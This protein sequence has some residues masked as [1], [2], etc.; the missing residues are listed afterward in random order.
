MSGAHPGSELKVNFHHMAIDTL[1]LVFHTERHGRLICTR[2]EVEA[3]A[4]RVRV[5]QMVTP[6]TSWQRRIHTQ[7]IAFRHLPPNSARF[8]YA[9]EGA[10]FICAQL[11]SDAVSALRKGW[12]LI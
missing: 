1:P 7:S 2:E 3:D 9:T 5:L 10:L 12:V 8:S 11:S 4:V 6:K